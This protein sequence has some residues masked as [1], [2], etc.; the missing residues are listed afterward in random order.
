MVNWTTENMEKALE[1]VR[2]ESMTQRKA[3]FTYCE[4]INPITAK[5]LSSCSKKSRFTPYDVKSS[6][7]INHE[8]FINQY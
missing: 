2:N 3:A 6:F 1:D 7:N 8:H 5:N 4:N